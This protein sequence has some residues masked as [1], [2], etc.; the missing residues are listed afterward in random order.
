[1]SSENPF[2]VSE[3]YTNDKIKSRVQERIKRAEQARNNLL[4]Y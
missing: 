1:M 2:A 3:K 4:N